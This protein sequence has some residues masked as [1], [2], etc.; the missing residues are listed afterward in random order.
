MSTQCLNLGFGIIEDFLKYS[1]Y[2]GIFHH[3]SFTHFILVEMCKQ[4]ILLAVSTRDWYLAAM[5]VF[6]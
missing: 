5:R 6:R 4:C 3:L 1:E 2:F